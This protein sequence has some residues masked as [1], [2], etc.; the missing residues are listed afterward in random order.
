MGRQKMLELQIYID[1]VSAK[2]GNCKEM[3][4]Q[5]QKRDRKKMRKQENQKK[6]DSV[7]LCII[8]SHIHMYRGMGADHDRM[9]TQRGVHLPG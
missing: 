6:R 2:G 5:G 1:A 3:Q 8:C 9:G 4:K 7:V